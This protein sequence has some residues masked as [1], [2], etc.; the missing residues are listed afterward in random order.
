MGRLAVFRD[1]P[2]LLTTGGCAAPSSETAPFTQHKPRSKSGRDGCSRRNAATRRVLGQELRTFARRQ[3]GCKALLG[4]FG[5]GELTAVTI[6]AELGDAR[7]FS[8]STITKLYEQLAGLV[9]QAAPQLLTEKGLGV[10]IA[11]KLIVEIAG[12][13]RFTSDAQ[14]ARISGCAPIPVS[15]GRTDRHRLDPGGNR[16]LNH[17]FHMLA[18]TKLLHDPRT[19]V[20]LAKQRRDGKSNRAAIRSHKRPPRPP[21]LPPHARPQQRPDHH[22]L[23]T[24]RPFMDDIGAMRGQQ[25][26]SLSAPMVQQEKRPAVSVPSTVSIARVPPAV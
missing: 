7:R 23:D 11:A 2:V 15:S 18:L 21:R 22:L 13:D 17:A 4:Q 26:Q 10:L 6:L 14:L 1:Q 20:Y 16:Q 9:R 25:N 24:S 5:V 8:S 19:A 12:V 3:P